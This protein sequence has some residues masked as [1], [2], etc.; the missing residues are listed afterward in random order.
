[1][2]AQD[3]AAIEHLLEQF[4][5]DADGI[6]ALDLLG[7][8]L[9]ERAPEAVQAARGESALSAATSP[10]FLPLLP[11]AMSEPQRAIVN[12]LSLGALGS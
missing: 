5:L 8:A 11:A 3:G 7:V 6:A 2:T 10:F 12:A 9:H 1:M 4:G